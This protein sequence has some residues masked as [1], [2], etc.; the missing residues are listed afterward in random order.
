MS[1]L[2]GEGVVPALLPTIAFLIPDLRR[3]GAERQMVELALRVD[4]GRWRVVVVVLSSREVGTLDEKLDGEIKVI[5]VPREQ[6]LLKFLKQI[7]AS[8]EAVDAKIVNAYLVTAQVYA[9][10]ARL[11]GWKGSLIFGVRDSISIFDRTSLK[12]VLL[13]IIA[14]NPLLT[15][16]LYIFNSTAGLKKK[17][18]LL[19]K[20]KTAVIYNAIN[21]DQFRPDSSAKQRLLSEL[22]IDWNPFVVGLIANLSAYKDAPTFINAACHVRESSKS[23]IF[24]VVG[25]ASTEDGR[26]AR[27]LV[28]E[29]GLGDCFYFMGARTD[30]ESLTPGFDLVVSSSITEG[31][32][33]S[34][35]E[36]MSSGVVCVATDVGDSAVIVGNERFVVQPKD[37]FAI[38]K[39]IISFASMGHDERARLGQAARKRILGKFSYATA[40]EENMAAY[41]RLLSSE[42]T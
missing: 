26:R 33:N 34:I 5:Y 15:P 3:G 39:V 2:E 7:K 36:A 4:R 29:L 28:A 24:V 22:K 8:L 40:V 18:R 20:N 38:A 13:D 30:V 19:G 25:N 32:S 17:G 35:A 6:G 27:R 42:G 14:Y 23:I 9:I 41:E 1:S 12:D 21:T 11:L 10:G 37:D 31:F 16:E